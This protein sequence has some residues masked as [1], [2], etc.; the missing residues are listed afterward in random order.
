MALV[1]DGMTLDEAE[2]AID[3]AN[4]PGAPFALDLL[5]TLVEKGA[6][7]MEDQAGERRFGLEAAQ[8]GKL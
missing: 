3:G 7:R 5:Q 6:L 1:R 2:A 4:L 8:A